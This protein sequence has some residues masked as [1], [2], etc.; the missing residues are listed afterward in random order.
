MLVTSANIY[1]IILFVRVSFWKQITAKAIDPISLKLGVVYDRAY[2]SE[3]LVDFRWSSASGIGYGF[4]I[5]FPFSS[6]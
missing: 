5:T 3:E 6:P 4:Q 2:E 1:G